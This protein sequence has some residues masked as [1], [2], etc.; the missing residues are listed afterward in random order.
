M[1]HLS[2]NERVGL[3]HDLVEL[4]DSWGVR[5]TD[6]AKILGLPGPARAFKRYRDG[7]PLPLDQQVLWHVEHLLGIADALRTT[8]PRNAGMGG[9]WMNK[10]NRHLKHR[11]PL[12]V[13]IQD[14]LPG[15]T[16]VRAHLD[17]TYAW[18]LSGSSHKGYSQT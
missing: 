4:L 13:L 16:R 9:Y 15:L 18:D 17:C 8:F 5:D 14:G 1:Q 2:H 7:T 6:K 12:A 11:S 3:T 10:P